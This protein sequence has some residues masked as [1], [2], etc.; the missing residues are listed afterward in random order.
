ME[1]KRRDFLK[2]SG[3][4]SLGLVGTGLVGFKENNS[5]E[6]L[7]PAQYLKPNRHATI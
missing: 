2:L 3:L 7:D 5:P 6:T 1:N 4:A